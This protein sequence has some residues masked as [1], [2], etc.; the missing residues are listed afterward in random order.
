MLCLKHFFRIYGKM[1]LWVKQA[2]FS[3]KL[4]QRKPL[5]LERHFLAQYYGM[6]WYNFHF[7]DNLQIPIHSIAF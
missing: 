2:I 4:A 1:G 3:T 7:I 6:R 5:F